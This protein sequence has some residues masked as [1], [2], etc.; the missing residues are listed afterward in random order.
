MDTSLLRPDGP[1]RSKQIQDAKDMQL[2]VKR[3]AE[4]SG[5]APPPYEFLELVG[6]GS[7]GRVYKWYVS[8]PVVIVNH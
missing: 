2:Q 4:R 3:N 1:N 6:K 7:F 5:S 8:V